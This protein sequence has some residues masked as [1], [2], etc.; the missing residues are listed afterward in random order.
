[1][2]T[3]RTWGTIRNNFA[4]PDRIDTAFRDAEGKTYLFAGDQYVRYS[5]DDYAEVDEG[6]PR[7]IAGTGRPRGLHGALPPGFETAVDASFQGLDGRTYLFK[8]GRYAASGGARGA[9]PSRSGGAGSATPSPAPAGS[10]PPTPTARRLLLRGAT[11]SSATSTA[12]RTAACGWTRATRGAWSS[13]SRTC[14]R[15]SRAGSRR[16]SPSPVAGVHLFKDGRTVSPAPGDRIVRRVDR[17]WG[18]LGPV[19]PSGTVDAAFVGLDGKTYLFSGDRYLRYSGADYSHVD[20]GYPRLDR[21]G[22]GRDGDRGRRV[23]ARR[24]GPTCSAPPGC[25]SASRSPRSSSGPRYEHDLDAGDVPPELRERLLAHGL[26][27]AADGRVEGTGP[28]WTV[29][30]ERRRAASTVRREADAL[31]V[32]AVAGDDR[33]VLRALLGTVLHAA[34]RRATRGR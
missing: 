15:S 19:L 8:G 28:E 16:P 25:C 31:T 27:L 32:S 17:R 14:P 22:L 3:P 33:A 18:Q 29:P 5:G 20:A 1:M 21:R 23:R 9:D 34:R 10:T 11:R 2:P 6:Y 13:T 12:S 7:T 26:Q 24:H 4:D 30:I